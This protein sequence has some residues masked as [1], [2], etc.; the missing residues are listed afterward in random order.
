MI[1]IYGNLVKN[2]ELENDKLGF[3]QRK[4]LYS[5]NLCIFEINYL[6][7]I[8]NNEEKE[9]LGVDNSLYSN[10]T[11]DNY[12]EIIIMGELSNIDNVN[13]SKLKDIYN[14]FIISQYE[15]EYFNSQANILNNILFN[16]SNVIYDTS[17]E[18]LELEELEDIKVVISSEEFEKIQKVTN[19]DDVNCAICLDKIEGECVKLKCGHKYHVDCSKEWLCNNSNKCPQCKVKIGNG[20]P[21]T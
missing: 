8:K 12:K 7:I 14:T 11:L 5:F 20:L 3:I 19:I 21:L 18:E 10:S 9:I 13:V 16:I 4:I 1:C 2:I 15:N 6:K 17:D